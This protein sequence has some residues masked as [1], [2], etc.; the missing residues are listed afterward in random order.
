[1][2][3]LTDEE[4]KILLSLPFVVKQRK[5][6]D[7]KYHVKA[8]TIA[9]VSREHIMFFGLPATPTQLKAIKEEWLYEQKFEGK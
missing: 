8:V 1:M 3:K 9:G 5:Q 4:N 6:K 2:R 7:G